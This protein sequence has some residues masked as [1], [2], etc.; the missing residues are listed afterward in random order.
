MGFF[1]SIFNSQPEWYRALPSHVTFS[2]KTLVNDLEKLRNKLDFEHQMFAM[3]ILLSKPVMIRNIRATYQDAKKKFPGCS[4]QE[5][6]AMVI[7]DRISKKINAH[8]ISTSPYALSLDEL[9]FIIDSLE[10]I[11]SNFESFEDAIKYLVDI[12][13][14]EHRWDD[15]SGT[16]TRIQEIFSKH[17]VY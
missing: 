2:N 8:H 15:P 3:M 17:Q 10:E 6:C 5:Y 16:M 11:T 7:A 4:E 9:G 1:S 12:E 14:L 13:I